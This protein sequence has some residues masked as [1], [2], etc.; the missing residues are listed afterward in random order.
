MQVFTAAGQLQFGLTQG[1]PASA[2]GPWGSSVAL[3]CVVV[4]RFAVPASRSVPRCPPVRCPARWELPVWA[5]P[6]LLRRPSGAEAAGS[7]CCWGVVTAALKT[8][9]ESPAFKDTYQTGTCQ[10]RIFSAFKLY[11]A[12]LPL[13]LTENYGRFWSSLEA[14][15]LYFYFCIQAQIFVVAR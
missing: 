14:E 15:E 5:L 2:G 4:F 12:F 9:L 3:A 10:A 1:S 6:P 11:Y 8:A 7:C 13:V